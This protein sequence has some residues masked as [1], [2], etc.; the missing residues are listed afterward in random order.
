MGCFPLLSEQEPSQHGD[1]LIKAGLWAREM[2]A[3][4]E[5]SHT[6]KLRRCFP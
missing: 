5:W 4:L 1:L 6:S 2:G 3:V